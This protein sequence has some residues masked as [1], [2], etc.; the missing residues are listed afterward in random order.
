MDWDGYI[1]SIL[2]GALDLSEKNVVPETL[3]CF[4]QYLSQIDIFSFLN[5]PFF[6]LF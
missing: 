5:S 4:E 6:I 1:H 2:P 3:N